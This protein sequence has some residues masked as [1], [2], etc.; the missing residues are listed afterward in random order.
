VLAVKLSYKSRWTASYNPG[1]GEAILTDGDKA[2]SL[3]FDAVSDA[4]PHSF[5]LAEMITCEQCLRTNP[6]TRSKCLYC[7]AGLSAGNDQAASL[8]A[9]NARTDRPAKESEPYYLVL[10]PNQT[11]VLAEAS[12]GEISSVLNLGTVELERLVRL[13]RPVPLALAATTEQATM[14]ADKLS[15]LGVAVET[16]RGDT[17]N[18]YL[19]ARKIRALELSDEAL[20]ATPVNGGV[21]SVRWDDLIV[22]VS[23]HL[24]VNRVEVEERRRRGRSQP[25]DTRELFSDEPVFDL[26]T[27]SDEVGWRI[28]S[29]SFDFS[30]LETRKAM[31][32][33]ENFTTLISLLR[34]RAPNVEV[35]DSYRSL[36]VPL[37]NV[38]PLAPE[39]KKGGWRRTGAGKVDVA[40]VT[41]TGNEVQFNC[42]S[43]LRRRL[44]LRELEGGR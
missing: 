9:D 3:D 35:D 17:L 38:W 12:L 43:R 27:R 33:F 14:L 39:T 10:G 42:Y 23:G 30:C 37:A 24:V 25:L 26:Y 18:L 6:P 7:G 1:R 15:K 31:T 19:A 29:S 34:E 16:F 41:T 8:D 44:K 36:R 13:G 20:A 2:P 11:N 32:A 4:R 40:T 5:A 22:L 28:S 21:I